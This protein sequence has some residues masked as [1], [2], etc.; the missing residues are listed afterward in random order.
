MKTAIGVS[1]LAV[2]AVCLNVAATNAFATPTAGA[3]SVNANG[4]IISVAK[5]I[6]PKW[7]SKRRYQCSHNHFICEVCC[8]DHHGNMSCNFDYQHCGM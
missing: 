3:T 4:A 1:L 5:K 2:A 7:K 6:R 8:W